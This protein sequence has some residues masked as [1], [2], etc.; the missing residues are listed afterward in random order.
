MDPPLSRA[1][2]AEGGDVALVGV[3]VKDQPDDAT[4]GGVVPFQM[5]EALQEGRCAGGVADERHTAP[6]AL[7]LE[8]SRDEGLLE[9]AVRRAGEGVVR[10]A[11][12]ASGFELNSKGSEVRPCD[13]A[14]PRPQSCGE[15]AREAELV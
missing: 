6:V 2:L 5:G 15:G 3:G 11:M 10:N 7:D 13:E 14:G 4:D 12:P 9:G 8:E 1:L